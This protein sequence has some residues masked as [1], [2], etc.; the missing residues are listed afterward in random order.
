[1]SEVKLIEYS[2]NDLKPCPCCGSY[3]VEYNV[4]DYEIFSSSVGYYAQIECTD[5]GLSSGRALQMILVNRNNGSITLREDEIAKITK[6]W[7]MRGGEPDGS[8]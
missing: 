1:M 3:K 6:L 4:S 7:N 2:K 5:C 8:D